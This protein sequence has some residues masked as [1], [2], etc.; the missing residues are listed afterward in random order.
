[1]CLVGRE[2]GGDVIGYCYGI[3]ENNENEEFA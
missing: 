1:M 3:D 2:C